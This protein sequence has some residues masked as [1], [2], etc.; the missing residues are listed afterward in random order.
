MQQCHKKEE[1]G[2]STLENNAHIRFDN[3]SKFYGDVKIIED[4]DLNIK[5]GEFIS[6]LGPSGSGKTHII[7]DVGRLRIG[8]QGHGMA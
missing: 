3:I 7:D 2:E 1:E 8:H 4:L 5:K 6:L